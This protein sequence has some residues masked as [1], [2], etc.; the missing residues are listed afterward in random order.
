M[1]TRA[2]V[3]LLLGCLVPAGALSQALGDV[4]AEEA[5]KRNP[6]QASAASP[7]AQPATSSSSHSTSASRAPGRLHMVRMQR[8]PVP[9]RSAYHFCARA[10]TI[11]SES[12]ARPPRA[13]CGCQT[14]TPSQRLQ[15]CPPVRTTMVGKYIYIDDVRVA[16]HRVGP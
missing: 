5:N 7:T 3:L 8:R 15:N 14:T 9:M 2:A 11:I 12:S 6:G 10:R 16:D 4:A 1:R 13:T